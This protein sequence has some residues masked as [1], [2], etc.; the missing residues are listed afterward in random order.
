[1]HDEPTSLMNQGSIN[2]ALWQGFITDLEGVLEEEGRDAIVGDK[3]LKL[4]R[5]DESNYQIHDFS[6]ERHLGNRANLIWEED[7]VTI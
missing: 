6:G 5:L 2:R 3:L 4:V 1:M 7:I